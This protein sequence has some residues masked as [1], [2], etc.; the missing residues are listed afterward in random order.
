[1]RRG[2]I[3]AP[4]VFAVLVSGCLGGSANST[5]PPP[6]SCAATSPPAVALTIAPA[7]PPSVKRAA[8]LARTYRN[9]IASPDWDDVPKLFMTANANVRT[10]QT[11][12][13]QYG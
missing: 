6:P 4:L 12:V 9:V 13:L 5:A 3:A 2:L 8:C 1:M 7:A 11:R 10:W